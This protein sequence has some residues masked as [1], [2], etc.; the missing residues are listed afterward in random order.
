MVDRALVDSGISA[1]K[2]KRELDAWKSNPDARARGWLLLDIDEAFP[3]VEIAFLAK[4][5]VSNAPTFL[6][7]VV[8]A[9]RLKYDNYDLLPPS[10]TFIDAVTRL[11]A[12]PHVRA[13]IASP[14]GPQDVLIDAHPLTGQPFLC[15]PGIREYHTHPQHTGD[16]WLL[17]RPMHT[18][19]IWTVC[20]R[21]WRLMVRN[22]VGLNVA[23]Q[24]LPVIPLKAQLSIQ[25][26]QGDVEALTGAMALRSDE[27]K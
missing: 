19:A 6:P 21:I 20:D 8:C 12:R 3:S 15:L 14:D 18:G 2:F 16:D 5:G 1:K 10:L 23:M 4:L 22:V 25:I 27:P 26:A 24:A 13:I 11:P 9:A 7:A 17:H